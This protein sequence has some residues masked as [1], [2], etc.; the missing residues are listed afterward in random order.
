MDDSYPPRLTV[1]EVEGSASFSEG[2]WTD[3]GSK[4][5]E[6]KV[7]NEIKGHV[8]FEASGGP[9][10]GTAKVV[11]RR[12]IAY[13]T[14]EDYAQRSI[15]VNLSEGESYD[16][17]LDWVPQI[18]SGDQST[19][20]YHLEFWW[21]GEKKWTMDD[22]YPPRLTVNPEQTQ[23]GYPSVSNGYWTDEGVEITQT[24]KGNKIKAHV[25]FKASEGYLEGNAKIV[26][27][28][29]ISWGFD[30]DYAT[31][32][33]SIN[34]NKDE[35]YDLW[36]DWTPQKATGEDSTNGYHLEFW[37]NGEKKWT[38]DDSYPPRLKVET[39]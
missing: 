20:G 29:D 35:T 24:V 31:K 38:M 19:N 16:L 18:A 30:E 5:T 22:S 7:G 15:D 26:V 36:I 1:N 3:D 28:R 10:D 12:D 37:W 6:T 23:E 11:V 27:R 2:Y 32:T 9:I 4:I 17:S 33:E 39:S 34:I 21:N 8:N 13:S 25:N 14:D